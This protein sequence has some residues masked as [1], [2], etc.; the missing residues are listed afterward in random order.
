MRVLYELFLG[1]PLTNFFRYYA[2]CNH[3]G[4]KA[5]NE[6]HA[7]IALLILAQKASIDAIAMVKAPA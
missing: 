5:L 2:L 4:L 7:S 1:L 6:L 3:N